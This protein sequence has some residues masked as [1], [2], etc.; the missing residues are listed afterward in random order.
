MSTLA[1]VLPIGLILTPNSVRGRSTLSAILEAAVEVFGAST[2]GRQASVAAVAKRIEL[3][4]A[5]IYQYF[6]DRDALVQAAIE[7]DVAL[8]FD[9]ALNQAAEYTNPMSTN[10]FGECLEREAGAHP[11]AV[12]AIV[13]EGIDVAAFPR[14]QVRIERCVAM[15]VG[16]IKDAQANG[17]G[18]TDIEVHKLAEAIWHT[19]FYTT[20]PDRLAGVPDSP[21]SVWLRYLSVA[22]IMKSPKEADIAEYAKRHAALNLRTA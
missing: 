1:D 15:L 22:A 14:V 21:R 6:P 9:A 4:P 7:Q 12:S 3:S 17:V 10:A 11:L 8:L 20:I 19:A 2:H 13:N 16:E 18:R 5:A